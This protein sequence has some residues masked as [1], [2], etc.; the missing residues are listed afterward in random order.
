M[1]LN[2]S[3]D[4]GTTYTKISYNSSVIGIDSNNIV[5]R[6]AFNGASYA[7]PSVVSRIDDDLQFG[8][9]AL[10]GGGNVVVYRGFKLLINETDASVLERNSYTDKFTP[11]YIT[12]EFLKYVMKLFTDSCNTEG[13]HVDSVKICMPLIWG[14]NNNTRPEDVV[15]TDIM[16]SVLKNAITEL[17]GEYS[18]VFDQHT[19]VSIINEPAAA[20]AM[21]IDNYKANEGRNYEGAILLADIGGG[22]FDVLLANVYSN[23]GISM[24][25]P[26]KKWGLGLHSEDKLGQAGF[27][28][29]N[30]VL[31]KSIS[32]QLGI[33][34]F[35]LK[36]D[37]VVLFLD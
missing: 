2:I 37:A 4:N 11:K 25:E 15:L 22:T 26:I 35:L 6:A 34:E 13:L 29:I 1:G 18:K 3:I 16:T 8:F 7:I 20:M 31:T 9:D 27:A 12:K 19:D 14:Q 30:D 17:D 28:Y 23:D 10:N 5:R 32:S 21:L 33:S 24:F 36:K